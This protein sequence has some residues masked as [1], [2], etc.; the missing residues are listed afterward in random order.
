MAGARWLATHLIARREGDVRFSPVIIR[1]V[2]HHTAPATP[3]TIGTIG[4]IA[5]LGPRA[6]T[7][8][9]NRPATA[10]PSRPP[11]ARHAG[12]SADPQGRGNAEARNGAGAGKRSSVRKRPRAMTSTMRKS[13]A[14]LPVSLGAIAA[15]AV[16]Q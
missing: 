10:R 15:V 11:E 12:A 3:G 16:A 14:A 5:A 6:L 1:L 8:S 7:A 13:V 4:T 2:G 9:Q